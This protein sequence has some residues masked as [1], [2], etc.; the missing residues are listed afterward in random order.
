M[1]RCTPV[2][3]L[4]FVQHSSVSTSWDGS[5]QVLRENTLRLDRGLHYFPSTILL[6]RGL[7][8]V[9]LRRKSTIHL[10]TP[11]P[12]PGFELRSYGSIANHYSRGETT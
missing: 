4:S 12:S 1:A 6:A 11:M 2:V 10:Q 7:F 5:T 9:T 3:T 8:R